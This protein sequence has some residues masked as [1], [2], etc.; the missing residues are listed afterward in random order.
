MIWGE[1]IDPNFKFRA[2]DGE[3]VKYEHFC[4]ADSE[5]DLRLRLQGRNLKVESILT[6]DFRDWKERAR[7]A[8]ARAIDEYQAGKRPINFDERIWV[9]LKW[10]LFELFH[11][12][13]AY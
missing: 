1:W 2:F 6:F 7:R 11:G 9:E 13:C 5:L 3:G 4:Y 10:H 8:T 12:K